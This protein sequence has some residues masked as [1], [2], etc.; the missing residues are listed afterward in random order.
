MCVIIEHLYGDVMSI[1]GSFILSLLCMAWARLEVLVLFE[2][3]LVCWVHIVTWELGTQSLISMKVK[4]LRRF[5]ALSLY[6]IWGSYVLVH[7]KVCETIQV[8]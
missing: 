8:S 1:M 4:V 5:A 2:V 7:R 6:G 3:I